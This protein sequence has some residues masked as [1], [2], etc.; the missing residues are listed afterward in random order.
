MNALYRI[1]G[2]SR[3]H[4]S[5]LAF[6]LFPFLVL[7][8]LVPLWSGITLG[9]DYTDY[10]LPQMIELVFAL[11]TGTFALFVPGFA[12]GQCWS[13]VTFGQITHPIALCGLLPGFGSGHAVDWVTL[14]RLVTLGVAHLSL[15]RL[16]RRMNLPAI[17]AFTLSAVTVYNH[18]ML[19]AF[20]YGPSLES[21]TGHLFLCAAIGFHSLNQ[22][23]WRTALC[24]AGATYWVVCSGHPQ[25]AYYSLIASVLFAGIFPF[26]RD[27]VIPDMA[28]LPSRTLWIHTGLA[29]G[30]GV[31]LA[32][33][34]AFPF[35]FDFMTTNAGRVHNNYPWSLAYGSSFLNTLASFVAPLRADV[36]TAFGGS[37]FPLVAMMG[38]FAIVLSGRRVPRSVVVA[39]SAALIVVLAAMGGVTPVHRILWTVLPFASSFRV[40]GR[41]TLVLPSLYLLILIWYFH[42]TTRRIGDGLTR[43]V[44]GGICLALLALPLFFPEIIPVGD[45]APAILRNIPDWG[46][47][48]IS[49]LGL[50]AMALVLTEPLFDHHRDTWLII[51]VATCVQISLV[52]SWG[53]WITTKPA[54]ATFDS[55]Q[56]HHQKDFAYRRFPGIYMEDASVQRFDSQPLSMPLASLWTRWLVAKND[57][58][59]FRLVNDSGRT[60]LAL[61]G[62][63]APLQPRSVPGQVALT[64][65]SYNRFQFHVEG[66]AEGSV[67]VFAQPRVRNWRAFVN[68]IPVPVYRAEACFPA[69]DIPAGNCVVEWR[70]VSPATTAGMAV[71]CTVLA[72]IGLALAWKRKPRVAGIAL[73]VLAIVV[74][75]GWRM[76]L[77][78]GENIGMA[79]SWRAAAVSG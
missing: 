15:Y 20:R 9:N 38:P 52:L 51:A 1:F 14:F 41:I 44:S 53:T 13:A 7:W 48:T 40:A 49:A 30:T 10:N 16:L 72:L 69:I 26:I 70:Y 31:L 54:L 42:P 39:W 60:A 3:K 23:R 79:Y 45:Y 27:A 5:S 2:F 58:E 67:L 12:G 66:A 28:A 18:R 68:D 43:H 50:V 29:M 75:S 8:W 77:Y 32:S 59:A 73:V 64:Y 47:P 21:I 34:Y 55:T 25:M 19:D 65:S 76:S 22:G 63:G 11:R 46:P 57:D 6:I 61:E 36:H 56:A 71:S 17:A 35:L 33:S 74:F 37:V 62:H 24:M 78:N 4:L